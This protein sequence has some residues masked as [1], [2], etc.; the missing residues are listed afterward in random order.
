[1]Q[2]PCSRQAAMRIE[3]RVNWTGGIASQSNAESVPVKA[4]RFEI[5]M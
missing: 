5:G 3:M 4:C 1:M 2:C